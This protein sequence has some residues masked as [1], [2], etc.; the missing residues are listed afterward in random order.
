[1]V[2]ILACDEDV[3]KTAFRMHWESYEFEVMPFGVTNAPSQFMHLVQG[4]LHEYLDEF[5]IVFI[6][7]IL[8]FSRPA[9]EYANTPQASL[10]TTERTANLCQCF[11]ASHPYARR[12]VPWSMGDNQRGRSCKGQIECS[13]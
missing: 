10:S 3:L 11:E 5:I 7:N 12:R 6:D 8:I 1:M 13:A 4:I 9:K 2:G